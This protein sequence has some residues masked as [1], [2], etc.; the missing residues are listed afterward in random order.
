VKDESRARLLALDHC[1]L[2]LEE[3][4]AAGKAR[5]DGPLGAQLRRLLGQ[6]GLV[7]DH[8]LEGRRTERVLDDIFTLQEKILG[9]QESDEEEAM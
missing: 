3:A 5:V 4:L 2:L 7:A 6:A 8:R 1:L 9:T